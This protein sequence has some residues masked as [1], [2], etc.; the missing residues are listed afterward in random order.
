M[1]VFLWSRLQTF[2][3]KT[4]LRHTSLLP[5]KLLL[6]EWVF[7]SNVIVFPR[8]KFGCLCCFMIHHQNGWTL[9]IR[10][11]EF[12]H[13]FMVRIFSFLIKFVL[14]L[15]FSLLAI[16]SFNGPEAPPLLVLWV[17]DCESLLSILSSLSFLFF[18]AV[19]IW[20]PNLSFITDLSHS[21]FY[22]FRSYGIISLSKRVKEVMVLIKRCCYELTSLQHTPPLGNK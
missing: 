7:C 22:K 9:S 5:L 3:I 15:Y 11:I 20:N 12:C 4:R 14:E 18:E 19:W 8:V 21:P 6:Q 13:I 16:S 2:W 1:I 17:V 10:M